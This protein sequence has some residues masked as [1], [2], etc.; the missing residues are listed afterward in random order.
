MYKIYE[1]MQSYSHFYYYFYSLIP[2]LLQV[3]IQA[4]IDEQLSASLYR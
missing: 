3:Y 4:A 2:A 1:K